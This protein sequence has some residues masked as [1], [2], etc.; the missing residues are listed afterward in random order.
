MKTPTLIVRLVGLYLLASCSIN[1]LQIHRAHSLLGSS[2]FGLQQESIV[3]DMQ[4]Y[5]IFGLIVGGAATW[6]AGPAAR[7]LTFDSAS[8]EM[9]LSERLLQPEKG[10]A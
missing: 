9:D 2:G 7:L 1:L 6:L 8:N 3:S 5:S 10:E 4:L